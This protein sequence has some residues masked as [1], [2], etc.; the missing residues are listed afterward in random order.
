[1]NNLSLEPLDIWR[2]KT[3]YYQYVLDD[4]DILAFGSI[5]PS[6][7]YGR[8]GMNGDTKI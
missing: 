1:M 8:I 3:K 7:G 4:T 5:D 6:W 2:R